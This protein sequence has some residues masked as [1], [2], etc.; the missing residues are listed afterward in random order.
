M[1]RFSTSKPHH[2]LT[3]GSL[4]ISLNLL[5][6]GLRF[7]GWGATTD[8]SITHISG[9]LTMMTWY[10]ITRFKSVNLSRVSN[11]NNKSQVVSPKNKLIKD[12]YR[13][14]SK[15]LVFVPSKVSW[16]VVQVAAVKVCHQIQ[17]LAIRI[18]S[19]RGGRIGSQNAHPSINRIHRDYYHVQYGIPWSILHEF[20]YC[21]ARGWT[22]KFKVNECDFYWWKLLRKPPKKAY[23]PTENW[24]EAPNN[25]FWWRRFGTQL[26][27]MSQFNWATKK[28]LLLSVILVLRIAIGLGSIIHYIT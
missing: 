26:K 23:G 4:T 6:V 24:R 21:V 9:H 25:W 8:L 15:C 12:E 2:W 18:R 5:L 27:K 3:I 14:Y 22:K 11:L 19:F 16:F 17:L 13:R 20:Y 7:S 28:N 10:E 1:V